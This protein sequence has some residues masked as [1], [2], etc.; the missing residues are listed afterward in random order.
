MK[1]VGNLFDRIA[2]RGNLITAVW[3]AAR[4]K[5]N[6]NDV[7]DFLANTEQHV[8]QIASNLLSSRFE[9]QSYRSFSVRDTKTRIIQAPTFRDRVVH[10]AIINIAGPVFESGALQ[11]SYACR[12]G[13]GQHA[14]LAQAQTWTRRTSW[15]G[16]MDIRRYYD[17]IDHEILRRRLQRRFRE[18]RLLN[19]FDELLASW[20]VADGKGLPIGALTSQY[21]ANFY[22]DAFDARM[23][24]S[25]MC[26]RYLRYMDDIVVLAKRQTLP[27]IRSLARQSA[28]DLHLDIKNHGEWNQCEHGLPFLGFVIYPDRM[29]LGR[30]GRR[31][32]RGKMRTL[33]RQFSREQISE[34]EFQSRCTSL[35]SHAQTA[36]DV[37]WRRT[38]LSCG[39]CP[40]GD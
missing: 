34:I 13:K 32:L 4:E 9:F 18:R 19:L 1:A 37:N 33:R 30:Q 3:A 20:C 11:H 8:N 26:H 14:A 12:K 15:Y 28:A 40:P 23:K 27:D 35:F 17:S 7:I 6:R 2:D 25:G 5:R 36:D 39:D 24:A 29:R 22:L 16:K 38:V 21:L 10:H 31:R